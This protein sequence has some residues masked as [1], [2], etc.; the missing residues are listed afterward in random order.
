[1]KTVAIVGTNGIPARYGGFE[2]LAEN[3][4]KGAA[5]NYRF[6]VYCSNLQKADHQKAYLGARLIRVPLSANGWRAPIYDAISTLH[7]FFI[8]DVILL[9]GPSFGFILALNLIFRRTIIVNYGG[10]NEWQRKKYTRLQRWYNFA[11]NLFA[12]KF[13][14]I[15]IADNE[16]L[17]KNLMETFGT[18]AQVIRYGGDHVVVPKV[19][20]VDLEN[21][22]SFLQAPYFVSVSRAQVDNNLHLLI[23]AFRQVPEHKLVLISNWNVSAYGRDIRRNHSDVPNITLLDAIYDPRE[24]N[25]IRAKASAYIHTH[26]YCGTAPSL[27]EAI[28]LGLPILS[29]DV[30]TNRE[31]TNGLALYFQDSEGLVNLLRGLD[32][33][34]L[35][36]LRTRLRPLMKRPYRWAE[37]CRQYGQF[38]DGYPRV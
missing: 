23:D 15:H 19:P 4:V 12:A 21:R 27:V 30:S 8:A 22:H 35:T 34:A 31:T 36:D 7:A 38:F 11:S 16:L 26:S 33:V 6:I 25:Y 28:C 37:I 18:D 3:L 9:L 29:F 2:T 24:L 17:Q 14:T 13:A 20:Q 5:Q 32:N 1:M 10:L